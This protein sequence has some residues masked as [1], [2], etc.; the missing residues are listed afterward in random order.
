MDEAT[1]R[2]LLPIV[3][4][5][6]GAIAG[7]LIGYLLALT[8]ESGRPEFEFEE[9]PERHRIRRQMYADAQDFY[10]SATGNQS[11]SEERLPKHTPIHESSSVQEGVL[12][13]LLMA[14]LRGAGLS[15][16]NLQEAILARAN[17]QRTDLSRANLRGAI[18]QGA[19]LLGA[20][21]SGADLQ[22]ASLAKASLKG[23]KLRK[24]NLRGAI[25]QGANLLAADLSGADLQWADLSKADLRRADL[26]DTNLRGAKL[27]DTSL[28]DAHLA[29]ADL[30]NETAMP[31]DWEDIVASRPEDKEARTP[32]LTTE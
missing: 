7:G 30:D 11:Q 25:L 32:R 27:L 21:L 2:A 8:R 1:L 22:W 10:Y 18:L 28:K 9:V 24:A 17:L 26:S 15:G 5:V 19:N 14:D 4:G 23:T 13:P 12:P 6:L 31:L 20:E 29:G 16:A 3:I